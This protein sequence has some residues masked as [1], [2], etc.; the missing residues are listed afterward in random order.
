MSEA[1]GRKKLTIRDIAAMKKRGEPIAM[2]TAY[3]YVTTKLV[4]DAGIEMILVSDWGVATTLLGYRDAAQVKWEEVLFYLRG[5]CRNAKSALVVGSM[6]FGSYQQST[7][8]AVRGAVQFMKAGADAL[9][10][11]GAGPT[12]ECVRAISE[13]GVVCIGDLGATPHHTKVRGRSGA[14]G[15][16]AE[17]AVQLLHDAQALE[18][19]GAWGLILEGVPDRIAKA[20]CSE[21]ELI[22]LGTAG[23][24]GCDGQMLTTHSIL[25]MPQDPT[26]PFSPSYVDLQSR[27]IDALN[28]WCAEVQDLAFPSSKQ[29]FSIKDEQYERFLSLLG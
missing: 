21:T 4:E 14:Y 8:D 27:M 1:T 26:P 2:A 12:I 19:A 7:T 16:N 23:T 24:P 10:L 22:V 15:D 5:V 6:P 25:G 29:T 13:A 9:K 18:Q 17:E 20:V 28:A 11:E 3:D